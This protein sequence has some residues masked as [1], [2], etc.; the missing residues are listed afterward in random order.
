MAAYS[1]Q[2]EISRNPELRK[3]I[4]KIE[5]EFNEIDKNQDSKIE[6][7]EL[8]EFLDKKTPNGFDRSIANQIFKNMDTDHDQ[9][10][11]LKEFIETF[12][13]AETILNGKIDETREKLRDSRFKKQ[14]I[15]AKLQEAKTAENPDDPKTV[16]MAKG[17]EGKALEMDDGTS[18]LFKLKF[19]YD[20]QEI[21]T[22]T[23]PGPT[24]SWRQA[25]T[26][27]IDKSN[28]QDLKIICCQ[29][30]TFGND[31][32]HGIVV[33]PINSL[34]DQV[35]HD[36]WFSLS[37]P[38]PGA[39]V[40]GKVRLIMQWIHSRVLYLQK[41]TEDWDE[42]IKELEDELKL[43]QFNL[44]K[45]QEPFG[46]IAHQQRE[47]LA[48]R[49]NAEDFKMEKVENTVSKKIDE[50]R[51]KM[52]WPEPALYKLTLI[53]VRVFLFFSIFACFQRSDFLNLMIAVSL[54]TFMIGKL[55]GEV[56]ADI[57]RMHAMG[58][59]VAIFA[60]MLWLYNSMESWLV[61]YE[62]KDG[63]AEDTLK[64]W[65]VFF[66][67]LSFIFKFFLGCL[68]LKD[69]VDFEKFTA[70]KENDKRDFVI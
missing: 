28:L 49:I 27:E 22:R 11:S 54:W 34:K 19:T 8:L 55:V 5:S 32:E 14:S 26:F 45:L 15:S 66:S 50:Y 31:R 7:A 2:D 64:A 33:I 4:A 1:F 37:S 65:V 69:A 20:E 63:G 58:V 36:E 17:V 16:L 23:E 35:E 51:E 10:I 67:L 13:E 42:E 24:P 61:G 43:Y 44:E 21:H 12:I 68:L 30:D 57:F 41:L 46:L 9:T 48:L 25:F 40:F 62:E 52:N 47:I 6:P 3:R 60:D 18:G 38:K 59:M 29:V 56:T 53:F 70:E 39:R